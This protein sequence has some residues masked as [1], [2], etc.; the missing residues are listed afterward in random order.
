LLKSGDFGRRD[1][2]EVNVPLRFLRNAAG[3]LLDCRRA[4]DAEDAL[5]G[6]FELAVTWD[7]YAEQDE[8]PR[9]LET[10]AERDAD[11]VTRALRRTSGVAGSRY[12]DRVSSRPPRPIRHALG[13]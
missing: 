1:Y 4:G 13:A 10:R 6:F 2:N 7:R 12:R 3:A 8:T 9:W 5:A 11:V